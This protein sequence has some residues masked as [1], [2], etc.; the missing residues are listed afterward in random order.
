MSDPTSSVTSGDGRGDAP[1]SVSP[2]PHDG[3]PRWRVFPPIA[4]GVVMATLD[5]SVVNIAL[6][7]LQR[8]LKAPLSSI[9]WVALAYSLTMTGLLL[10]AGRLADARGRRN[11]YGNGLLLFTAASLL[12]GLAPTSSALIA[13]RVLQGIGAALVSANGSALLVQA[14]PQEERGRAL[15]A[16]GAMVGVGLAIGP[17]L[18][19]FVVSLSEWSWRWIFFINLPL[20]LLAWNMLQ[21]RVPKDDPNTDVGALDGIPPLLWAGGLAAVMLALTRA[22]EHGLNDPLVLTA[23]LGGVLLLTVFLVLQAD[24]PR[25]MLPLDLL[26]GPLGGAVTLTFL[27][28]LLSV[29]VGFLMPLVLEETGGLSAARS[30]AWIAVLPVAALLCAPLAGRMAD[31]VGPRVLTVT[32]ML[33]TALGLL[34]LS[35]LGVMPAGA[36]LVM[37]LLL[38]GVGQGLFAVPNASALLSLVPPARLGVASG[39]QGTTRSLGIA[40]GIALTGAIVTA[41]YHAHTRAELHLGA[42]GGVDRMAFVAGTRDT[43]VALA[44]LA[45]AAAWLAWRVRT[46]AKAEG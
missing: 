33:L 37:G 15:G 46:P 7:T 44:L 10:S 11:V 24:S 12:C 23:G 43:F 2:P 30:G 31:R 25:P 18:G 16:F 39:L 13:L 6:P 22:P 21:K 27:G 26:F 35:R 32:G 8:V 41:R 29:S 4:L 19:G 5:A 36:P 20:G 14:F 9:E 45:V 42:P 28:Q 38:I 1:V 17:P 34:L 40:T 3:F